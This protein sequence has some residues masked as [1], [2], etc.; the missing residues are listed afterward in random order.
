MRQWSMAVVFGFLLLISLQLSAILVGINPSQALQAS[1]Q[2]FAELHRAIDQSRSA[3]ELQITLH[4][5]SLPPLRPLDLHNPLPQ[6]KQQMLEGLR[7]SEEQARQRFSGTTLNQLS[8]LL[9][10][11]LLLSLEAVALALVFAAAA[12][13]PGHHFS[14]LEQWQAGWQRHWH[15]L[16]SHLIARLEEREARQALERQVWEARQ[17][18]W[19]RWASQEESPVQR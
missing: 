13:R 10:N 15:C 17:E 16:G 11:R 19:Q 4:N 5:L 2:R 1:N 3:S 7:R 12:Q 18:A 9:F 6:L 14:R 8:A